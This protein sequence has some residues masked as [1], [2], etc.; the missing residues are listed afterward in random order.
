MNLVRFGWAD[1]FKTALTTLQDTSLIPARVASAQR[2]HYRLWTENAV[3]P[4]AISGKLRHLADRGELPVVGDWVAARSDPN[5]EQAVI[6]ALLPR[7]SALVRQAAG[8]TMEPQVLAANVDLVFLVTSL[9]QDWNPRRIERALALVWEAGAQPV[10]LLTK[11]DLC[12]DASAQLEAARAVALGVPVHALSVL[13]TRGLEVLDSYLAPGRTLALIG[14]SGVGK[15]TLVNYLSG[16][17]RAAVSGIRADERGKHTTTHRELFEL[18]GGGLIIDTPGMRELGMWEAQSGLDVTFQDLEVLAGDC[19]F[20]DCQHER[21]PGCSVQAAIA[22]GTL[23]A[24]RYAGYC[25]LQREL[26]HQARR[27]DERLQV[28]YRTDTRKLNKQRKADQK[29]H[30]KR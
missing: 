27:S 18:P 23:D 8:N 20:H 21:E 7:R 5:Q 30:P 9:N 10:L 11:L 22:A 6:H 19:R 13:D 4:A 17:E 15:S 26:A 3:L 14:S 16:E 25:K 12:P 28:Q 1:P 24:A 2:E 29:T